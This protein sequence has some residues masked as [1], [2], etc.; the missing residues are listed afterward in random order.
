VVRIGR[1]DQSVL[2]QLTYS[3]AE[4][5]PFGSS[6]VVSLF[7]FRAIGFTRSRPCWFVT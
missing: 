1:W 7:V 6:I 3:I 4:A 2:W 5:V